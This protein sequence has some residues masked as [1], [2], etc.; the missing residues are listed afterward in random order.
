MKKM[1][2]CPACASVVSEDRL[3]DAMELAALRDRIK[4]DPTAG[5]LFLLLW[6]ADQRI[7]SKETLIDL[8]S[9]GC[10]MQ[11]SEDALNRHLKVA[12]KA[13]SERGLPC[14]LQV[15]HGVGYRL[16]R[17]P[18]WHWR[19]LKTFLELRVEQDDFH[20]NFGD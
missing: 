20:F 10:K 2:T 16:A 11:P 14:E 12:R 4:I 5:R 7:L 18:G 13:I 19:D 9:D 8:L 17:Y 1:I 15:V 6:R 3:P